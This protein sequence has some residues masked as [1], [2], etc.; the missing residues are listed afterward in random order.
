MLTSSYG[1]PSEIAAGGGALTVDPRSDDAIRDG[2]RTLLTDPGE[3]DR[4]RA[5]IRSRPG[6]DWTRYADAL[7]AILTEQLALVPEAVRGHHTRSAT[8][9]T[10][11]ATAA[12]DVR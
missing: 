4:L 5:E 12:E 10:S 8:D 3:R 9:E 6:S 7:W 11:A 2:M 1:A